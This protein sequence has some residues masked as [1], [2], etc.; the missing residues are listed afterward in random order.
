MKN[1]AKQEIIDSLPEE[2]AK[3]YDIIELMTILSSDNKQM[4]LPYKIEVK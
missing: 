2:I 4:I 3:H 1:I